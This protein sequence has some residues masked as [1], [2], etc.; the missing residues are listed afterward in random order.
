VTTADVSPLAARGAWLVLCTALLLGCAPRSPLDGGSR[1]D[2]T[3]E[4]ATNDSGYQ[5]SEPKV[6]IRQSG[7]KWLVTVFQGRQVSEGYAVRIERMTAHGTGLYIQA[8]FTVPAAPQAAAPTSPAQSVGIPFRPDGIW[9]FDQDGRERA[10][11]LL[12]GR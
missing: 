11:V 6:D 5:G 10:S 2:F 12:V 4:G 8:R 3:D 7:D 1:L 9:L